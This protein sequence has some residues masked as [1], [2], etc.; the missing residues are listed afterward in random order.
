LSISHEASTS[1]E[2]QA[3]DLLA[4]RDVVE[5]ASR[6]IHLGARLAT[7]SAK[8]ITREE[9]NGA[10][11][12]VSGHERVEYQKVAAAAAVVVAAIAVVAGIVVRCVSCPLIPSNCTSG[13]LAKRHWSTLSSDGSQHTSCIHIELARY[14][15]QVHH[16]ETAMI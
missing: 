4:A 6:P 3:E 10:N 11:T 8:K 14:T 7:P 9:Q 15:Y 12:Q 13:L 5:L 16:W 1:L 2:V